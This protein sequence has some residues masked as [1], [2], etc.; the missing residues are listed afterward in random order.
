MSVQAPVTLGEMSEDETACS[1]FRCDPC[2]LASGEMP[3]FL[4]QSG[5]G[6]QKGRLDDEQVDTGGKLPHAVAELGVH[7]E[8][9]ALAIARFA[10]LVQGYGAPVVAYRPF[11]LQLADKWSGQAEC[12]E[13]ILQHAAPIGLGKSIAEGIHRMREVHSFHGKR[14]LMGL[15]RAGTRYWMRTQLHRAVEG[16]GVTQPVEVGLPR[17]GVIHIDRVL[18]SI[19]VDALH[20]AGQS[21]AVVAVEVGDRDAGYV[22][23]GH[24]GEGHLTL[25]PLTGIE[26]NSLRAP[27]QQVPVVIAV[28]GW[29]LARGAE[30]YEFT[31]RHQ[32]VTMTRPTSPG[33]RRGRSSRLVVIGSRMV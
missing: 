32:R 17:G 29:H 23:G 27:A 24:T 31:L 18:E 3:V 16:S 22:V 8:R 14:C 21:E 12:I 30:Y 28:L 9:D 26:Q 7:D 6:I 33:V 11:P 15:D 4:G 10:D 1:G 20:D 13:P 19:E 5:I 2:G 25:R